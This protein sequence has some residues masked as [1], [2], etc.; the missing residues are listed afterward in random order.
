MRRDASNGNT[1]VIINGREATQQDVQGLSQHFGRQIPP[2]RYSTDASGQLQPEGGGPKA[3]AFTAPNRAAPAAP[4]ATPVSVNRN[5]KGYHHLPGWNISCKLPK[6]WHPQGEK[7]RTYTLTNTAGTGRILVHRTFAN[8]MSVV[9]QGLVAVVQ[10]LGIRVTDPKPLTIKKRGG[11][12]YGHG[13]YNA[14]DGYGRKYKLQANAVLSPHGTA[15]VALGGSTAESFKPVEKAGKEIIGTAELGAPQYNTHR[16]VGTFYSYSGKSSG[17]SYSGGSSYSSETFYTFDGRGNFRT[18][19][20][21]H[22]SAYSGDY[23]NPNNSTASTSLIND[24]PQ[25][26]ATYKLL[27]KDLLIMVYPNGNTTYNKV[28][29]FSNGMKLNGKTLIKK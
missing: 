2:G 17:S 10:G 6:D 12:T 15:L 21:S 23:G 8:K 5:K 1:G 25:K 13:T 14:V 24:S 20:N 11:K 3:K 4:Q 19:T 7:D 18:N 28:E 9:E 29:I 16:L 22:V 26:R 27:G